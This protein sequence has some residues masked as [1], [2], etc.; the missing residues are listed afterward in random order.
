MI[1][2]DTQIN[3]S[4]EKFVENLSTIKT[5]INIQKLNLD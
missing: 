2:I 1:L 5:I 4:K 3:K